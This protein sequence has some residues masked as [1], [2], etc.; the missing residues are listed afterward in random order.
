M[1]T[2]QVEENKYPLLSWNFEFGKEEQKL[3]C[4]KLKDNFVHE[5]TIAYHIRCILNREFQISL[6]LN[7]KTYIIQDIFDDSDETLNESLYKIHKLLDGENVL[8]KSNKKKW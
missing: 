1:G 5:K 8:K 7:N 4:L 6:I 3:Y 2:C